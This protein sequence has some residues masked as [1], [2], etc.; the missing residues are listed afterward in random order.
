[1]ASF[2]DDDAHGREDNV[3]CSFGEGRC[4]RSSSWIRMAKFKV[5]Q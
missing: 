5:R 4:T 2:F 3:I 1:M